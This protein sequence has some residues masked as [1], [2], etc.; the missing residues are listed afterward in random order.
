MNYG[1]DNR[2]NFQASY[3]LDGSSRFG[4]N[5]RYA[6]FY[7]FSAGWNISNEAFLKDSKVIS[8]LKLR[9]SYGIVGNAGG[10]DGA[11]YRQYGLYNLSGQYNGEPAVIQGQYRNPDVTWEQTR[12]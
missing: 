1:Y 5:N 2:Y 12:D 4:K 7:A 6:H 11:Y 10:T 9:G 8:N 3:R